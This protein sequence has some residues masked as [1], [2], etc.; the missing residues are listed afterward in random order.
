MT[1]NGRVEVEAPKGG[2]SHSDSGDAFRKQVFVT[3]VIQ[4][5]NERHLYSP[6]S[7]N[8]H[9]LPLYDTHK[10]YAS[11]ADDAGS[12]AEKPAEKPEGKGKCR[13]ATEA[14]VDSQTDIYK[15]QDMLMAYHAQE[16]MKKLGV[17]GWM[18]RIVG[19]D[20]DK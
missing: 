16:G 8:Q 6:N 11:T 12:N 1:L 17:A 5:D 14:E 3:P 15:R 9:A 7:F 4:A 10:L 2:A 18:N 13:V 19:C 20:K